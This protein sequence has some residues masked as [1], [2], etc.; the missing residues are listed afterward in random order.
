M[1]LPSR[2]VFSIEIN[3]AEAEVIRECTRRVLGGDPLRSV[4]RWLNR[5]GIKTSTGRPWSQQAL[6]LLLMSG[7]I[8]G[9][10]EHLGEDVAKA[11]WDPIITGDQHEQL[12]ALLDSN[13]RAPGSRVRKHYLSG[14]VFCSDCVEQGVKMR[15]TPQG[16]KLKYKCLTDIG[17]CNGRV[18][19]LVDLEELIGRLMVAKLSDPTTLGTRQ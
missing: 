5:E 12:V 9:R 15:V 19:G 4:V 14:F 7:R 1:G 13:E 3:P 17:G 11:V 16:S 6:R 10:R 8:A 2:K 18:I